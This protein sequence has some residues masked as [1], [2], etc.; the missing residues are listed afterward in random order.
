MEPLP[1]PLQQVDQTYVLANRRRLS[2][3]GGCDYFR[4]SMHQEVLGAI[5]SAL[6]SYGLN[7]AASRITTGNH[8]LYGELEETLADFFKVPSATLTSS[9]YASN[10][11]VA[12]ALQGN[13]SHAVID[14][15]AHGSLTD[16]AHFFDCPVFRFEHL[17]VK[18]LVTLLRQTSSCLS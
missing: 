13:F 14:Q 15:K 9:G 6:N 12:Q 18:D 3:F 16:A 5:K 11:I 2:Y 10:M 17:N 8:K 4:L 1:A 7:V